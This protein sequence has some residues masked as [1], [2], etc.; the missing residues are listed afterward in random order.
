MSWMPHVAMPRHLLA[1]ERPSWPFRGIQRPQVA[2]K[3]LRMSTRSR[4]KKEQLATK[5]RSDIIFDSHLMHRGIE[6]NE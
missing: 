4:K 2:I 5:V 6:L 3:M 1:T